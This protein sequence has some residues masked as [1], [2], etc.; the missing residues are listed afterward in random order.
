MNKD[1]LVSVL[2]VIAL[3]GLAIYS[4]VQVITWIVDG[5]WLYVFFAFV[6]LP[7]WILIYNWLRDSN[8][9]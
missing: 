2:L 9:L 1:S 4:I 7:V 6:L 8:I 3:I 5:E